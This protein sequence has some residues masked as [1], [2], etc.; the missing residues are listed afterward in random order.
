MNK[1]LKFL[2]IGAV[3]LASVVGC[4]KYRL[5][6]ITK[7]EDAVVK[8]KLFVRE[9]PGP[10]G[11]LYPG[12]IYRESLSGNDYIFSYENMNIQINKSRL[13]GLIEENGFQ[14]PPLEP[15]KPKE[16]PHQPMPGRIPP[17]PQDSYYVFFDGKDVDFEVENKTFY[18]IFKLGDKADITYKEMY[19]LTYDDID[20]D[21]EHELIKRSFVGNSFRDAQLKW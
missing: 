20:E 9:Y 3:A 10:N 16:N 1:L 13:P 12:I 8:S 7:H 17:T 19:L 2:G 6:G 14:M 21:G 18:I 4:K 15:S 5:E 11:Q